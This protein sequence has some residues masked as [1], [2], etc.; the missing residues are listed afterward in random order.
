MPVTRTE[1]HKGHRIDVWPASFCVDGGPIMQLGNIEDVYGLI[2]AIDR[3][4]QKKIRTAF[5][6]FD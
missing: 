6:F 2:D 5:G 3:A 4:T 1:N